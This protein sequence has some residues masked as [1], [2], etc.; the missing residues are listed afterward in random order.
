MTAAAVKKVRAA[1]FGTAEV[2]TVRFLAQCHDVLD[3]VHNPEIRI[4]SFAAAPSCILISQQKA[5]GSERLVS[6]PFRPIRERSAV[7]EV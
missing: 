3:I 7:G 1:V 6:N 4:C 5:A 2:F